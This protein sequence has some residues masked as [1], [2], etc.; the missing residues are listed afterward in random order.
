MQCKLL[1]QTK[2]CPMNTEFSRTGLS[3]AEA[4]RRLKDKGPND[5]PQARR[6]GPL[7]LVLDVL[8]EPM[9]ALLLAGGLIYLALGDRAE[10]VVLL[11]FACL[12]VGITV[13]QEARTER[14]LEALRDLTSPRAMVIRDGQQQRIAGRDVVLG[15][16]I[17]LAE[18]DRV[19]ADGQL[20]A[21]GQLTVDES[22]L[23]GEAVPVTRAEAGPVFSGTLVVGGA[24]NAVVTA[25][26]AD[27]KIGK[28]GKSLSLLETETPHLQQQMRRL[29]LTFTLTGGAVSL[30]V[31][32]LY[33]LTR[34]G[35]WLGATLAG[36]SVGMAMLPE[37]FPMVLAVFMAIGAW[38]ISKVRVLTRRAS[39]IETL[40]AASVL[41]TDKTGTLTENRM[42]IA[43]LQLSDGKTHSADAPLPPAFQALAQAGTRASAV[44]PYDPMEQAFHRLSPLAEG[45]LD[46]SYP[47]KPDLLAMTQVWTEGSKCTAYAKGAPEAIAA[48]C[49]LPKGALRTKVDAMATKGQ[50]VLAVAVAKAPKTLPGDQT[51]F[52]FHLLGL[53]GLV[54]PLRKGVP[55]AVATCKAAGIRVIMITG[56][57]PATALAIAQEAGLGKGEVVT[58]DALAAM[59][60]AMLKKTLTKTSV[61]ARIMPDQKLRLVQAL[62]AKGE[63]VAMT[64]DG[65]ND[66]LSLKAAHIG[67][68]MGGR[69]TDVAR[70]AAS[71]VLLDDDFGSIVTTIALGR[72]IY[73]NL[74]K[75][76]RFILAVHV[77]IAGLALL[78]LILGTPLLFGPVHI[79]FLEMIIDPVC[80]LVFEAEEEEA[81]LMTRPPR[82]VAEPLF[83]GPTIAWSL[84]QG[85]AAFAAVAAVFLA[86]PAYG[87]DADQTRAVTFGALVLSIIALILVNRVNSASVFKA[88]TLRNRAL[89]VV[90]AIV[91][92]ML[93]LVMGL[94]AARDL[95]GFVLPPT[96]WMA[97]PL[98]AG[99][100]VLILLE[101]LKPLLMPRVR[102]KAAKA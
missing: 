13:V 57:H 3:T 94:P 69:G 59:S 50:R 81:G 60:D 82:P 25:T 7:R 70:E 8:K 97:A 41:C 31:V 24:A 17:A 64:G 65:V 23:T 42:T 88:L 11:I 35:D 38:R 99:L 39:A 52:D 2:D 16:L 34:N 98:A 77:P 101:M 6:R 95:F 53:V 37:E 33:G 79:A 56:D 46:Q 90:L 27:S 49:G 61:F 43:G 76:M 9:L 93:A 51:G 21:G 66:A 68:A 14:V 1:G 28:I 102:A 62:K 80:A 74:R 47:L 86:A 40:G 15:D 19:P 36:I 5:L 72:R 91:A 20:V 44:D 78:P 48:L 75:A 96:P 18:G 26:G 63:I 67:V 89:G 73:D 83:S 12:S 32:A 30:A 4:A 45:R 100:G 87:L 22:L 84:L 92:A 58:G 29:V 71:I 85:L 10:A 54:D 55:K